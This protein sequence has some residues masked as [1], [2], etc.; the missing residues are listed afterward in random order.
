MTQISHD[1]G[2]L[3]KPDGVWQV[4]DAESVLFVPNEGSACR[5]C[6]PCR[7]GGMVVL[8]ENAAEAVASAGVKAG[9]GDQF[10][11]RRGQRAQWPD[12]RD[13]LMRPV[14][15]AGRSNSRRACSRCAWFGIRV[16]LSSSR[17]QVCTHRSMIGF[18]LG[19]WT[20]LSTISIPRP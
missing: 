7:L 17:R 4:T 6:H 14:A 1:A 10:G 2:Q 15:V 12:V 11:D 13:S 20:P 9:G 19:I 8:V 3:R 16:R 5:K 18:I